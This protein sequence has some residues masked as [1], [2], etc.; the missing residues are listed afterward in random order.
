[1]SEAHLGHQDSKETKE[2]KSES[3]KR[4][5]VQRIDYSEIKCQATNCSITGKA[6]YK[7][8]DNIRYCNK[9]GLRMLRHGKLE[10]LK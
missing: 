6:K 3:A 9:H 8:V 7:I 2:N 1:M 4:V 10:R 5:W